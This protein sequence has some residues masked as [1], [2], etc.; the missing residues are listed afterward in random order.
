MSE[1]FINNHKEF[2]KTKFIQDDIKKNR[3]ITKSKPVEM[4]KPINRN[5]F[6]VRNFTQE[7][8]EVL[9]ELDIAIVGISGRYPMS[10][11]PDEF[12]K[13]LCEGKDCITEIPSDRW[14]N[15]KLYD[16]DR[17]KKDRIYTKWGGFI[18]DVDKFDPLFF[19]I[20]PREAELM[21]P[22]E[23]IFIETVWHTTEDAGYTKSSLDKKKVGVFVG[24]MYAHYQL[25]GA[26]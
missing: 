10:N 19:N 26:E 11:D 5:R 6:S 4:E 3:P 21:D 14:D 20:S 9:K 8:N 2:I 18:R 23:R 22:Q 17:N 16:P 25:F 13:N 15:S 1:Y 12:W 7:S 24:V